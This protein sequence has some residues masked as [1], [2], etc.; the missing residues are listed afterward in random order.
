M[1]KQT[2]KTMNAHTWQSAFKGYLRP[3][4]AIFSLLGFSCGLPFGL[5]GYALS[6]WLA[7]SHVGLAAIG[8]FALVLLPYNF[9]FLWAPLV[10][11]VQLPFLA[12]RFGA[13]KAW[14]MC[15][16]I[17][18][19]LSVWGLAA[20]TPNTN[21]WFLPWTVSNE[22]GETVQA[23][24]PMQ[25]YL[26][27]LLTAFFA[28]SQ[29]IVVDALRI[30]TLAKE[31]YGEGT[32]MY[33]FG[34][35]MG[36]LIS[37]AGVV[38]LASRISWE[39]AY[40]GVGCLIFVGLCATFCVREAKII[41]T[42]TPM[43]RQ[44]W[45][46][47]I[48]AP[49]QNFMTHAHWYLILVFII[50]YKLCN[51]VLGRMALPFYKEMG[52]SDDE[53]ALVSGT[54]GPW[55]TMSGVAVGGV[56]AM[57]YPILKLLFAL[58]CVEILTSVVFGVFSLFPHS[59]PVFLVVILFDNIVGGM[60]GA[61]FAAYLSGLCAR[62]YAATQYALL[63]SLMMFSVS[64]ISVYSG[65]WATQMGWMRFF[66]FTGVLMIPALCLLL[67]LIQLDKTHLSTKRK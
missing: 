39:V 55:I 42:K 27:A 10:D 41:E 8:F 60:G 63:S 40:M 58:G 35:R 31:E 21:T 62:K 52:F 48:V 57:K 25:T 53:I 17:G 3:R 16:Q 18:L 15:F 34:Y 66:F 65:V 6:L 49:F 36:M 64:V 37:S 33:Q 50:L 29:D 11:R 61:V 51:A 43:G 38:A 46:E 56:L 26:F 14:L 44:F 24:I 9:K 54:I 67:W 59:I 1:K 28:A 32:S 12:K 4:I 2:D 5:I 30:N 47:M 13:K 19:I 45:Y 22:D 20:Q 7:A 23:F